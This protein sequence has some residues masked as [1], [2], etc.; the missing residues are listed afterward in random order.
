MQINEV[1]REVQKKYRGLGWPSLFSRL[2]FYAAPFEKLIPLVPEEG[3]IV[4]LGCGYGIFA[5]ML[6]M[7]FPGRHIIGF[8]LDH[9]KIK[10][11]DRGI[12]N[13]SFFNSDITK[14]EIPLADCIIL[15]H[16]LHHLPSYEAQ[17][18]L[19][20]ACVS[21][22][23]PG[24]SMIITEVDRTPRWKFVLSF[25]ADHILYP[26]DTIHFRVRQDFL[27]FFQKVGVATH[28]VEMH[29]GALFP[30]IT[31]ICTKRV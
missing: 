31:Y 30:H 13:V 5:N 20:S 29:Q 6:G 19:V 9:E 22:L 24:G 18:R 14:T 7:M 25:L 21:R 23:K 15:V 3:L 16:V 27:A 26:R 8:D 1:I 4:D 28:I 17:E 12:S 10:Y 2:K 11:A